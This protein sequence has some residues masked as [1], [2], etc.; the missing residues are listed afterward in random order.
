M[1]IPRVNL[2]DQD[3]D[4][5]L[6]MYAVSVPLQVW[7]DLVYHINRAHQGSDKADSIT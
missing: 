4:S 7:L 2:N 3:I 6:A 5:V 1:P